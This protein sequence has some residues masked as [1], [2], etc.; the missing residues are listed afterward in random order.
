MRTTTHRVL[1]VG[2]GSIG[3][4][5][6]RCFLRTGR[7][8]VSLC[9][10]NAEV[11]ERV[12][13]Q[14]GLAATY[15]DL[16]AA[17]AE[18]PGLAVICTPAHL[19]VPQAL[20]A[21]R[22]GCHLLVE[23]P[24][25]TSRDGVDA[26]Q[27]ALA[28][29]ALAASVAYVYRAHPALAEMREAIRGGEFGRP[30]QVTAA[31]GQ[32][33]PLYRPAYREIYYRDRAT[34]GGAVQDALTHVVNAVE[35]LVGPVTRVAADVGHLA[36]EGVTVEDTAHVIARHG[37]VMASYSLNQHQPPNESSITVV[38]ERGAAR[39]EGHTRRWLAC[40]HPGDDWQ[41]RGVFALERDDLFVRQAALMLD[42]VEGKCRVA[43]PLSEAAQTLQVNLA[44]LS[45]ATEERCWM[46]IPAPSGATS[47]P[48]ILP[49]PASVP[50]PQARGT[51]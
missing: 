33:F 13:G 42:A 10:V 5:H 9:E 39:F 23:K 22:A 36:L 26:L 38:C 8:D 18:R 51:E 43:C 28:E 32:H 50:D 25:S 30:L 4:R 17:L 44:I 31:S 34:G 12:G 46:H 47:E 20:E 15:P 49:R 11:R 1:V 48:L 35:W 14:Y 2:G 41:E 45:A 29:R 16:T 40:V 7:A 27:Q 6:V 37:D 19:H 3:E 24:L 21:A